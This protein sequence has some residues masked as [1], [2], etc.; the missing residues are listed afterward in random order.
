M[1]GWK[2]TRPAMTLS[3]L[4]PA[5]TDVLA[6]CPS[7]DV[8]RDADQQAVIRIQRLLFRS[9]DEEMLIKATLEERERQQQR[10]RWIGRAIGAGI[11]LFFGCMVDGFDAGV[12]TTGF[13][14]GIMGG[15]VAD[16]LNGLGAMAFPGRLNP[17]ASCSTA[18]AMA[19][20]A[21]ECW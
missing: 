16:G 20:P 11:G 17:A 10:D 18:A 21:S 12:L 9:L 13:V 4:V 2:R 6:T 3:T 5:F 7:A 19:C 8:G 1:T 15:L 14:T